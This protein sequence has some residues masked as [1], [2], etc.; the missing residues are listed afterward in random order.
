MIE[1]TGIKFYNIEEPPFEIYGVFKENGRFRRLPEALAQKLN[2][3]IGLLH[4]DTAGGRVRFSTDSP[5]V[6]IRAKMRVYDT[7]D[8]SV[9]ASL[10]GVAAFDM[11]TYE[12]GEYSFEGVY[13]PARDSSKGYEGIIE[14]DSVPDEYV[15]FSSYSNEDKVERAERKLRDVTINFPP[16]SEVEELW[17][18]IDGD[19]ALTR[20]GKYIDKP[21]FVYYGSSITQGGNAPRPGVTYQA[22][23]SRRFNADFIN[24]GFSEGALGEDEIAE[25]I[26]GLEMSVF[27]YDYDHNAPTVE[28]LRRTHEKMFKAIR[29][30]QP[31]LPVI[32]MTRPKY[33]HFTVSELERREIIYATY[34]N[35]LD[36]GDKNVWFLDGKALMAECKTDGTADN[37]HPSALGFA[38]MAKAVGDT[39]EK[40]LF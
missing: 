1:K 39:I 31:S 19:A 9:A 8:Y 35:A 36:S 33:A 6:A 18:G 12:M 27:I 34:K 37:T 11:Y 25:Y 32:M 13:I 26:K 17:I 3:H 15:M 40:I 5:Y 23:I 14:F 29:A 38:S 4:A 16:Y 24:L 28:H 10:P 30:A 22:L 20:G 7:K 21:P 2:S